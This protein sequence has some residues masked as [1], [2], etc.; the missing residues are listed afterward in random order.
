MPFERVAR[1]R[2][3]LA[4]MPCVDLRAF[5]AHRF[6]TVGRGGVRQAVEFGTGDD[7]DL[8]AS[9]VAAVTAH[10]APQQKSIR[11]IVVPQRIVR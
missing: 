6:G 3:V 2:V 10:N 1:R 11:A 4:D 5:E 8:R 9:G 7:A